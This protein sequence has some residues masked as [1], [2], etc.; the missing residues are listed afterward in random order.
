MK[1]NINKQPNNK[2]ELEVEVPA[3]QMKMYFDSAA[4]ELSKDMNIKG[5]R[6]GKVPADIVEREKGSQVLYNQAVNIAIQKTLPK[7]LLEKDLEVVGQPEISVNQIVSGGPMKYKAIFSTVPEVKLGEYKGLKIK[8]KKVKVEPKEVEQSLNY[9]QQSRA[10]TTTV[11]RPA[12]KGDRVQIDF[13]TRHKDKTKV[14]GGE[15]K[16][17]A[18]DLGKEKFIPGFEQKLE[19]MTPGQKKKFSL[20]VPKTWPQKNLAG[21]DLDFEVKLNTV[22]QKELPEIS[23]EFAKGLGGFQS[24]EQLKE[25]IK[26]GIT[27]EKQQKEDQRIKMDLVKKAA[28]NAEMEIPQPL[29]DSELNKMLNELKANVQKMGLEFD[30]YL[31]QIKKSAEDLKKE[32]NSQAK[33]RVKVALTLNAIANQENIKAGDEEV[34]QK[35]NQILKNYPNPEEAKKKIDVNALKNY[36]KNT[37]RNEKVFQLLEREAKIT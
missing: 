30:K 29:I 20:K 3:P 33:Q 2:I 36:T 19:K 5:F 22:Q 17:Y 6:P 16:N 11:N 25:N 21:K 34:E 37:I 23:D 15:S 14:E 10:K 32:W 9:L 35:I 24:L 1:V 12:K 8:K 18:L 28:E 26:Q 27:Q 7:I 4:S 31:Q 13:V